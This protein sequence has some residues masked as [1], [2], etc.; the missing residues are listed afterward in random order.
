MLSALLFLLV[1]SQHDTKRDHHSALVYCDKA[2]FFVDVPDEWVVDTK[3]LKDR[4]TPALFYPKGQD[5]KTAP[6]IIYANFM[7]KDKESPTFESVINKDI[8]D[9]KSHG[10]SIKVTKEQSITTKDHR[11]AKMYRFDNPDSTD[12]PLEYCAYINMPKVVVLLVLSAQA[13]A[14]TATPTKLY[15]DLIASFAGAD[16]GM[17]PAK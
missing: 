5:F 16:V 12:Q 15:K 2:T 8:A 17:K 6:V 11:S 1:T 7:N 4:G 13:N 3:T 10:S 9:T 14:D